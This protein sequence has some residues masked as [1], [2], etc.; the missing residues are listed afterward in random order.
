MVYTQ[1]PP[2]L[3]DHWSALRSQCRLFVVFIMTDLTAAVMDNGME[4]FEGSDFPLNKLLLAE[5][6]TVTFAGP[7]ICT[8]LCLK[9]HPS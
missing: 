1:W 2:P 4:S 9:W 3:T 6:G 8:D 7:Q 5:E